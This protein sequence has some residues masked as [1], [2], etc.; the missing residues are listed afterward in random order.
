MCDRAYL[1]DRVNILITSY[2]FSQLRK[3]QYS[4]VLIAYIHSIHTYPRYI[5][6][7][8]QAE[9]SSASE[10]RIKNAQWSYTERVSPLPRSRPLLQ[11][12]RII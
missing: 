12:Q 8:S 1:Y 7:P 10:R 2:R 5:C 11:H 9:Q 3:R 6:I 4:A